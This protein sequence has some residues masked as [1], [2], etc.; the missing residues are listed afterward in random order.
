MEE[1]ASLFAPHLSV[2]IAENETDGCEEITFP[3]AIA[4]Y[5]D[6]VLRRERLNDGLILVAVVTISRIRFPGAIDVPF[7]ALDDDLLDVHLIFN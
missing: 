3:R 5:N 7:E 1:S 4:P 6:V 2:C